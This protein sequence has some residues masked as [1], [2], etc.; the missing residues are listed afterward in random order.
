MAR[1]LLNLD[2]DF[3]TLDVVWKAFWLVRLRLRYD[4]AK[5]GSKLKGGLKVWISIQSM[6]RLVLLENTIRTLLANL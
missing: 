4:D 5:G 1:R 6:H 3:Q 2:L